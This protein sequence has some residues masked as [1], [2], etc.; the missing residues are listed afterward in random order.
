M[1]N[2]ESSALACESVRWEALLWEKCL[3]F[4]SDDAVGRQAQYIESS[5]AYKAKVGGCSDCYAGV[6]EGRVLDT[7]AVETL[8]PELEHDE[9][10]GGARIPAGTRSKERRSMAR[11][12]RTVCDA[13]LLAEKEKYQSSV[14]QHGR[15]MTVGHGRGCVVDVWRGRWFLHHVTTRC[16][17]ISRSLPSQRLYR[18]DLLLAYIKSH[19][20]VHNAQEEAG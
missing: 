16:F 6:E 10:V 3:P 11:G 13:S 9:G 20:R 18:A 5:I 1:S 15:G 12:S 7:V 8:S 17:E 14:E 4:L 19:G 2:L